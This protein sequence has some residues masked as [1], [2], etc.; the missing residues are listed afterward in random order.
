MRILI[1]S[2]FALFL[3][4][5]ATPITAEEEPAEDAPIQ[6]KAVDYEHDDTALHGLLAWPTET[7]DDEPVRAVLLIHAWRGHGE[8]VQAKARELAEEGF[9]A[10]ALD[11]YGKG[12]YAKDNREASQLAGTFYAD[13]E[14][15]RARAQAGLDIL[16]AHEGVTLANTVAI[17]FCF[18][19]TV[20]LEMARGGTKLGGVA[21]FH[22]GLKTPAP[23]SSG[24]IHCEVLVLHGGDDPYVPE[25][26]LL[27][28]WR[29][30]REARAKHRIVILSGAVHAFTD[31]AAGN[32]PSKGAAYNAEAAETAWDTCY[33][34]F[35]T[36]TAQ[37]D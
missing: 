27:A 28:F 5:P 29:E 24:D 25:A 35:F 37:A 8:F 1:A 7:L 13:R 20:V 30:M 34:F 16:L 32:D 19:G 22:G 33:D 21:S 26:E 15:M 17:G 36:A 11:M 18:G 9:V 6:V 14:L 23:A 12:V 4:A 3:L 31:P 10:F 2:L